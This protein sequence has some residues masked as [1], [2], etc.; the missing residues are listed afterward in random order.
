[1]NNYKKWFPIFVGPILLAFLMVVII[2][3]IVGIYFSFTDWNG[4]TNT[5]NWVGIENYIKAFSD[6][7]F[8]DAFKFTASF[9]VVSVFTINIIGFGLALL[10]TKKM[11]ISNFLRSIFFMPN[12]IGGIILGF[13]WQFIFTKGFASLG[14]IFGWSFLEG[15]LS[16]TATGFWGLVILMSWQ[17]SGY[18]MIIYIAAIQ[19]IPDSLIEASQIDGANGL[20]K[21]RHIILPLVAP[22]FT[23]G[24][25]LSLSNSFKLFD[26]NLAL[27]G[28]GPYDSTQM[29][30]LNIYKTAFTM[31]KLGLAQAKAVVF[32]LAVAVIT[33]TQLYYSKKRE[34]EM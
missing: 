9:A 23:V 33:V 19:S 6:E 13:V 30:A 18:M 7:K 1:M 22:A 15:W 17:M 28:G 29:L 31:N 14:S 4:I 10:V 12:L 26:Q 8:G 11:K 24:I 34:V 16:T 3:M 2:P 21:L 20:Q 27:T 5:P 25:F 32:L